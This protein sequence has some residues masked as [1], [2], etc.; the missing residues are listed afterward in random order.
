MKPI[1]FVVPLAL[2][3]ACV[4]HT[5]KQ[6]SGFKPAHTAMGIQASLS[7]TTARL[8]GELLDV[9]DTALVLLTE[10]QVALVPYPA[11]MRATFSNTDV[12]I[13]NRQRPVSKAFSELRLLSRFPYGIPD[14]ALRRLLASKRQESLVVIQP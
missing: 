1:G 13:A 12:T 8:N 5:G 4:L 3:A 9:R 11:I 14:D 2:C 6:P 10:Q 7:L